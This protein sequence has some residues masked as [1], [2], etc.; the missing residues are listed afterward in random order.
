MLV[1]KKSLPRKPNEDEDRK[2]RFNADLGRGGGEL[3]KKST[4]CARS[5]GGPK[6]EVIVGGGGI[7]RGEVKPK[8][9]QTN[10]AGI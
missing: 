8:K 3:R 1:R 9:E 5:A 2:S 10:F 7:L 4:H 6:W